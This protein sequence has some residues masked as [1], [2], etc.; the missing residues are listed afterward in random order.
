MIARIEKSGKI[1]KSVNETGSF[2]ISSRNVVK[3]ALFGG[4][5]TDIGIKDGVCPS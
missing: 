1:L 4:G 2:I 3:C 5:S